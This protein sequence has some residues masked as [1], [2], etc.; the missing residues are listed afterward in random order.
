MRPFFLAE[1][2]VF[3]T[4]RPW[5]VLA[6]CLLAAWFAYAPGLTGAFH[7]DDFA[8]LPILGAMGP[9]DSWPAFWRYITAGHA[10]PTGRP[11]ALLTFLLDARNWPAEP[12]PFLRTN[13][14]LH[15]LN[16]ALLAVLLA[17]LGRTIPD[18]DATLRQRAHMAAVLGAAFWTLHPLFVSTTLYVVQREAMLPA[19]FCLLGLI[20]WLRGRH[21]LGNGRSTRGLALIALGLGGCTLLATLSKAN[22][23]LLP[24]LALVIEIVLLKRLAPLR[25]SRLY[26]RAMLVFGWL[27]ALLVLAYLLHVGWSGLTEG[28]SD[29]R[30]WTLAQRLATEPRVLIGYLGQLWLPRPYSAG[31]FNDQ[32]VAST[33]LLHPATTLPSVLGI[34]ALILGAW[35]FRRR[36][37]LAAVAVLFYFVGHLV[38][39]TTI[40]LELQFEHRNYLPALLMFWPLAAWLC[41]YRPA[42]GDSPGSH[43]R[44]KAILAVVI[45]AGLASMTFARASLWGDHQSQ[46]LL[47]ATIN[48]QS[49]RA[50]A[51][52]ASVETANGQPHRAAR[53][54]QPTLAKMPDDVQLALGL[55]S[56]ECAMGNVESHTLER[57]SDALSATRNVGGLLPSWFGRAITS[58]SNPACPQLNLDRLESLAL[59][60]RSNPYLE[61]RPGSLQDINHVLGQIDLARGAP[62]AAL[63]HFNHALGLQV[64][65]G[66][67]LAQASRLGADGRP[68]LGLAHLDHYVSISD[69]EYAPESGM[70]QIHAWILKKQGYW[71]SEHRHL[72]ETL[73]EDLQSRNKD[74]N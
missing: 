71:A 17:V 12:Y 59:A 61:S 69:Q 49:A 22:G 44:L 70:P 57:A 6:A 52:A 46:A 64:R 55:V 63:E 47:W 43:T 13:V 23:A 25:I 28:I 16:G 20:L 26:Q 62:D 41:G 56:A 4:L 38:E 19:T 39:S 34:T 37:P 53:R 11:V 36:F 31:L 45:L 74:A 30:P 42:P 72:R 18:A 40:A 7:F 50:Q 2:D 73:L 15:L 14:L 66:F 27:P 9:I 8:N 21:H 35:A 3:R 32:T 60:A 67:A 29:T 48:P 54:L 33:S 5:L 51:Y 68:A 1:V 10:D 24:T 65:E 58:A